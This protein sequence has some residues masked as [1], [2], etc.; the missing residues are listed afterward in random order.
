M[1]PYRLAP[2]VYARASDG[3]AVFLNLASDQYL[4]IDPDQSRALALV[5]EDWPFAG[6]GESVESVHSSTGDA[7]AF[8]RTLCDQG[9]LTAA[10]H[11]PSTDTSID[12]LRSEPHRPSAGPCSETLRP[13]SHRPR[14]GPGRKA[15]R[16]IPVVEFELIPWE[17]MGWRHIR[18]GHVL[19]FLQSLLTA[20][21]L[22]RTRRFI[23]VV[24]RARRRKERHDSHGN[25]MFDPATGRALLSAFF[26]IRAFLYAPKARCLLDSLTLIEFL[27]HYDQYPDWVIGVQIKPFGS[28]S[29]VQ[30]GQSV[31]NGTPTY[32]RSYD[33][34]VVI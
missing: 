27:A 12:A 4:G 28:H 2:D 9:L 25:S 17:N 11:A 26:H 23:D 32:V 22:L 14:A 5:V 15:L 10:L 30:H 7:D 8:A 13:E 6:N 18:L 33:S 24:N 19:R 1:L 31:L 29:W 21:V 20:I 16:Q 34:I 3:G